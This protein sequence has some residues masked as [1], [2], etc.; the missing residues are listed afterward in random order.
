MSRSAGSSMWFSLLILAFLG[1]FLGCAVVLVSLAGQ[2]Y[3]SSAVMHTDFMISVRTANMV[4]QQLIV[5]WA[6]YSVSF[7]L[8]ILLVGGA[9]T[10]F[11]ATILL[12]FRTHIV[13]DL[14]KWAHSL[15]Y[16]S[17]SSVRIG[18]LG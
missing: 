8:E 2:Q 10:S 5:A 9:I 17:S 7:T 3:G 11:E 16:S 14:G 18:S 13:H 1:V 15:P 4:T 12:V 6:T